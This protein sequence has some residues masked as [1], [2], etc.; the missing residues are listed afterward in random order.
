[1]NKI[2]KNEEWSRLEAHINKLLIFKK[3]FNLMVDYELVMNN[4]MNFKI[5]EYLNLNLDSLNQLL[6]NDF[7]D[8]GFRSFILFEIM[9]VGF[10]LSRIVS[11]DSMVMLYPKVGMRYFMI[12]VLITD[13][14]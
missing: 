7:M 3:N 1:M 4:V 6:F 11:L 12:L 2:N 10:I 14:T 13:R 5:W 8:D 9:I